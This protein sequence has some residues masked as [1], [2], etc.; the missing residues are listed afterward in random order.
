MCGVSNDSLGKFEAETQAWPGSK[1]H[2]ATVWRTAQNFV[3]MAQVKHR[4]VQ[5]R[6]T[7]YLDG[8]ILLTVD[9]F[10]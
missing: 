10:G 6:K 8:L 7:A 4:P 1:S 5:S 3:L 2:L 9:A